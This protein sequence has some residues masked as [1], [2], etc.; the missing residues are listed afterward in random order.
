MNTTLKT[1]LTATL[2][3]LLPTANAQDS[4][5][6]D[7]FELSPFSVDSGGYSTKSSLSESRVQTNLIPTA[8]AM[9]LVHSEYLR[10]HPANN[11]TAPVVLV[12]A[13]DS[14]RMQFAFSFYD[15]LEEVRKSELQKYLKDVELLIKEQKGLQ[16]VP[17]VLEIPRSDRKKSIRKRKAEYTSH[18][19]FSI[20]ADMAGAAPSHEIVRKTRSIL[21]GMDTDSDVSKRFDGP[22]NLVLNH[23]DQYR[24]E[25]LSAIFEDLNTLKEGLGDEYEILPSGINGR[26]QART[27]SDTEVEIWIQYGLTIRSKREFDFEQAKL[28]LSLK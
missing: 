8:T 3:L 26:V 7:V 4:D 17:G 9:D 16:F 10:D 23:P 11:P 25:L 13:A 20:Y 28:L 5:S 22:V 21:D 19:H 6:E 14:L 2:L 18:A 15:D 27:H 1:T 24:Q 12:K